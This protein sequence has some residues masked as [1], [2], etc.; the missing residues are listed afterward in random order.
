MRDLNLNTGP[1]FFVKFYP[2]LQDHFGSSHVP[3]L[4]GKLEY[5]FSKEKFREG[6]FKFLEPCPHRLCK[7][8][9]TW[10]EELGW[11]RS[12]FKKIFD[13]VGVRYTSKT[14]YFAAAKEGDPFRGKLYA[15][16]YD[17]KANKNFYIRNH[18]FAENLFDKIQVSF[19]TKRAQKDPS[20]PLLPNGETRVLK[21]PFEKKQQSCTAE[22][23][24]SL[25]DI[26]QRNTNILSGAQA[27][28][29]SPH[30]DFKE[31]ENKIIEIWRKEVRPI[32]EKILSP[33][34]RKEIKSA[35]E[36]NFQKSLDQW[37]A[38]C[39]KIASSKF[40][41]GE[42]SNFTPW[43]SWAIKPHTIERIQEN[44]FSFG[45]R[46]VEKEDSQFKQKQIVYKALSN[47]RN[48][49]LENHHIDKY[50]EFTMRMR[51]LDQ[52]KQISMQEQTFF[53]EKIKRFALEE[54]NVSFRGFDR[55]CET[56]SACLRFLLE[57]HSLEDADAALFGEKNG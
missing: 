21:D 33:R 18:D 57:I 43:L 5:W 29:V 23:N 37:E 8:G 54:Q 34:L 1:C 36:E 44:G 7:K 32:S 25:I 22:K 55:E 40:L 45:D 39:Q 31:I 10:S 15:S 19:S 26:E 49:V 12:L 56:S 16:Y 48:S 17:R 30:P 38:Y 52:V 4:V 53:W 13:V 27:T 46:V 28:Q 41:M 42:G 3:L 20:Q 47:I 6:F 24:Q 14:A 51:A 35:F 9:D 50:T 11:K 2:H